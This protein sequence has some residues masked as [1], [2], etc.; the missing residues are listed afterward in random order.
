VGLIGDALQGL[1]DFAVQLLTSAGLWGLFLLMVAES[2][3]LPV[4]SEAVMPFAGVLAARSVGHFTTLS[5][6]LVSTTGSLVGSYV[7]YGMGRYGLLPLVERFGRYVLVQPHHIKVA[8]AYFERRGTWAVFLCRFVPG[9]RHISSIPAG[10]ARM[11]HAHF[12]LATV[13]G[14]ALWNMFLY[15]VG[16]R[17]GE[18]VMH[19]LKPYLDVVGVVLLLLIVGY[20]VYEVR[21]G[22]RAAA[23]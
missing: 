18:A 17:Y 3:F 11:P 23:E 15:W 2:M 9:V 19:Q 21:K 13:A 8:Q 20:V 5:V 6:L 4:P 14:A 10:A 7:G 22:K 1:F 16:Y 12:A